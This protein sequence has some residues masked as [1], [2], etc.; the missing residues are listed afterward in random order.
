M[1]DGAV[2]CQRPWWKRPPVWFIAIAALA[3]LLISLAVELGPSAKLT[4]MSYSAFLDQLDAGNIASVTFQGT[5]I[6]GHFKRALEAAQGDAFR[7][8]VP[9]VGDPTLMPALRRQYVAIDVTLPS[10]WTWLLGS[11]P[12]PMLLFVGAMLIAAIARILRGATVGSDSTGPAM[13]AQG[14]GMIG[15]LSGLFAKQRSAPHP[16]RGES[17]R[18][19]NR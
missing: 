19:N 13:P 14:M 1:T 3:A 7:T 2:H 18:P 4:R 16:A 17:D 12:W 10:A 11:V 8:R 15:L 9:D 6:D 5:N